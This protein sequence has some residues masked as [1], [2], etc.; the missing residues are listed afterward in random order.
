MHLPLRS[1]LIAVLSPLAL[2]A[3]IETWTAPDGMKMEAEF[4]AVKGD[5]VAFRKADG[6]RLVFPLAKLTAADRAR[7]GAAVDAGPVDPAA[8]AVVAE[9]QPTTKIAR[10][11]NGKLVAVEGRTLA[12]VPADH[13]TGTQVYAV[14]YSAS[15]CPPCR[16]FTP[17]LVEAY[18]QI[19]EK[20]PEF[21]LIF[22]SNDRD[23]RSMKD[24]MVS[25]G[26]PWTALRFRDVQAG[27]SISRY[28]ENGIPNL[29]FIDGEGNVLSK[30]YQGDRYLGPDKVLRDIRKHFRM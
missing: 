29:V 26:M 28:A 19:K 30:S 7:I 1:L 15:W 14:Y 18:K 9:T 12:P 16:A 13:L 10:S 3:A 22:V 5:Y 25:Y 24:Y 2:T 11:L 8:T 27:H 4:I 20:H 21:E 17:E 23:E 6:Q